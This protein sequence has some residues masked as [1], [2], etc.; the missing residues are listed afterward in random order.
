MP[1]VLAKRRPPARNYTAS[2]IDII[3]EVEQ[4]RCG[5]C[6]Q[7]A[8]ASV[9]ETEEG[10]EKCPRCIDITTAAWKAEQ[11]EIDA[12]AIAAKPLRPQISQMPLEP[13]RG[14]VVNLLTDSGGTIV[15]QRRPLRLVR[16]VARVLL[17]NGLRF[18][19]GDTISYSSGITDSS[20]IS[21]T[22]TVTTLT[23]VAAL[24]MAPGDHYHLTF[25]GVT[26]R[27]VFSVR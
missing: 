7:R 3:E 9:F 20:A 5:V 8:P 16:N 6:T 21:R 17:V 2:P 23:V 10:I 27:D 1:L 12:A 26:Y 18:S 19:S 22:D 15:D 13:T 11:V 14:A 25:N 4:K 24:A